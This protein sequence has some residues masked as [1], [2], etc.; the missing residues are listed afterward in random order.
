MRKLCWFVH[1]TVSQT[2]Q[3]C[4]CCSGNPY[5]TIAT[6]TR[7]RKSSLNLYS[8]DKVS[9]PS[10]KTT[11][12]W[13]CTANVQPPT[14]SIEIKAK[15]TESGS[16]GLTDSLVIISNIIWRGRG[17]W[18]L[19]FKPRGSPGYLKPVHCEPCSQSL[20][21]KTFPP[22]TFCNGLLCFPWYDYI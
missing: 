2:L 4:N 9:Y 10:I 21:L 3:Y 12:P 18:H 6:H 17:L 1:G 14:S 11:W 22:D 15:H 16:H 19:P 7:P 20:P 5:K 13:I 8:Q